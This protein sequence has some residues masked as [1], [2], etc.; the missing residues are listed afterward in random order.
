MEPRARPADSDASSNSQGRAHGNVRRGLTVA[1]VGGVSAATVS[2]ALGAALLA[3]PPA[4]P[5]ARTPAGYAISGI[6]AT[7][8]ASGG[9]ETGS[10]GASGVS[11]AATPWPVATASDALASAVARAARQLA[12]A[13]AQPVPTGPAPLA[14]APGTFDALAMDAGFDSGPYTFTASLDSVSHIT[15]LGSLVRGAVTDPTHVVLEFPESAFVTRYERDGDRATA[16]LG[17]RDLDVAPGSGA[18]GTVSPEDLMPARLLEIVVAPWQQALRA[19]ATPGAYAADAG[20]L[21]SQARRSGLLAT[22]WQ[23]TA[24]EDASGRLVALAFSGSLWSQPFSL[25]LA[26]AYR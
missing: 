22:G 21:V 15:A 16:R 10:A 26:V 13:I 4:P 14:R 5:A 20:A 11:A 18:F 1:L 25:D 23:L 17:G 7:P 8:A 24:R 2:V 9:P 12:V 6:E 3:S 19:T